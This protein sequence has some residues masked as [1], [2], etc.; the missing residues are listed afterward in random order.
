MPF[1]FLYR[2]TAA[3]FYPS[4]PRAF[5]LLVL[6]TLALYHCSTAALFF[7]L[8]ALRFALCALRLFFSRSTFVLF[9]PL[10]PAFHPLLF[11]FPHHSNIPL[12]H[13]STIPIF[14][15]SIIP[16]FHYSIIFPAFAHISL[17]L[18]PTSPS[19]HKDSAC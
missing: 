5:R 10:L 19:T 17:S 16:L 2:S 14:Q 1:D 9:C 8:C 6:I 13:H 18:S 11:S 15:H 3:L 7:P 4:R 12:F